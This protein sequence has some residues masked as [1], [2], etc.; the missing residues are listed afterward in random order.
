MTPPP[1]MPNSPA[2]MPVTTPTPAMA[3]ARTASSPIGTPNISMLVP[4]ETSR[5]GRFGQCGAAGD[6]AEGIAQHLGAGAG[7]DRRDRKMAAEGARAR[8]LM[9]QSHQMAQDGV[10]PYAGGR[11]ALHVG[12]QGLRRHAG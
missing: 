3:A 5:G 11:L 8:H 1:P 6:Q 2:I 12:D 7:L 9:E 4:A 10:R